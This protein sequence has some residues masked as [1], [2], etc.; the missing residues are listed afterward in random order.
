MRFRLDEALL[1]RM[2]DYMVALVVARFAEPPGATAAARAADRLAAA[3]DALPTLLPPHA[4][5]P[6]ARVRADP[7]VAVW[8]DALAAFDINPNRYPPSVE[9]LATRVAKGGRLPAIGPLVDLANVVALR[10]LV[11]AGAH[12]LAVQQGDLTVRLASGGEPFP[13]DDGALEPVPAGE[14]VYMDAATVRTRR[15]VWRQAAVG[16]VGP[17]TTQVVFPIDGFRGRTDAAVL[18]AAEDLFALLQDLQPASLA[19][20]RLDA[21]TLAAD[22]VVAPPAG[23]PDP[24]DRPITREFRAQVTRWATLSSPPPAPL[25][26]EDQPMTVEEQAAAAAATVPSPSEAALQEVLE[27]GVEIIEVRADLERALRSGR[28]LRVKLGI[29]PTGPRIHIGRA[30]QLRKM[31]EF[32][33]L[34]HRAILIVGDLTAQ[35]GDASGHNE[36]RPMLSEAVVRENMEHYAQQIGMIVDLDQAE[37]QYNSSWL[38]ALNLKDIINLASNFTAAQMIQR[39]NFRNRWEG[40]EPIG[41]QELLYPLMQ[42]YNSYAIRADVELG[43]TDQLFNVMAGRKIQEALGQPP[44]N[45]LLT[46]MVLGLDG[47]KMS[48]SWGNTIFINDAPVDQYGKI[49]STTDEMIVPYLESCTDVPLA[50][51]RRIAEDLA[52]GNAHP[53]EAKKLLAHQI[54]A[55]YHGTDAADFA[56][57]EF[58]QVFEQRGAPSKIPAVTVPGAELP[59][60]ELL[61]LTGQAPSKSQAR[62]VIEQGGVEIDDARVT[63]TN[64]T[65]LPR[66][67]MVVKFGKRS[68]VRLDVH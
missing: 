4:G 18:A 55:Q 65:V 5:G 32:Q 34:G 48:T 9:A 16:R 21:T 57:H 47:R 26:E 44:Q 1:A 7:R 59:V 31:R 25:A 53:K 29:D 28:Q 61:R 13:G 10:H 41:M 35:V 12:D 40:G 37:F 64:A 38:N 20:F 68:F 49:M 43:G 36:E 39:E 51:V 56:Q 30:V 11:P 62:R 58:E 52:T 14:P 3:Q 46:G 17:A 27:R 50:A 60:V 19:L 2:P 6:V 42:G 8:R 33:R 45:I 66:D 23:A 63:D 67:G 22:L 54:V 24:R 15:W